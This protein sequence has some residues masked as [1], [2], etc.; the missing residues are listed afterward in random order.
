MH[1]YGEKLTKQPTIF[2][3]AAGSVG[4]RCF[5]FSPVPLFWDPSKGISRG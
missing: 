2:R 1:R 5:P 4:K 3:A